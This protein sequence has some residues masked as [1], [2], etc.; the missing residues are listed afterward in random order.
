MTYVP[1]QVCPIKNQLSY[2]VYVCRM[3]RLIRWHM[4]V[5]TSKYMDNTPEEMRGLCSKADQHSP[6][7]VI[8]QP[9]V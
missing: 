2:Y 9:D 5:A 7:Y 8:T 1:G 6:S 4:Q 3:V